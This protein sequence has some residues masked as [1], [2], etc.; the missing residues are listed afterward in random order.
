MFDESSMIALL[1]QAGFERPAVSNFMQS[2]ITDI[3]LIELEQRKH[4][5][6]YVESVRQETV[7]SSDSSN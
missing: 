1:R 2:R 3:T 7:A 4:E 5:S 6:L